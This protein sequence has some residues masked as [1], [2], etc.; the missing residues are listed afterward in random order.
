[1]KL[2]TL[3]EVKL[4]SGSQETPLESVLIELLTLGLLHW[5]FIR[6]LSLPLTTFDPGVQ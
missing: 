5:S 2:F 1:M 3:M 6:S 4:K